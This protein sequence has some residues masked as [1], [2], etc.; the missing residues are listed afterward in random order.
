MF[1]VES[2]EATSHQT[3]AKLC[4]VFTLK[5]ASFSLLTKLFREIFRSCKYFYHLLPL[6]TFIVFCPFTSINR[7][8]NHY[9]EVQVHKCKRH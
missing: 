4:E 6:Q 2:V 8:K 1:I 9:F 7:K 3:N 5:F